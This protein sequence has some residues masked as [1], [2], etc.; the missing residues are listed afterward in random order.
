MT[1]NDT[2]FALSSGAGRAAIAVLRISGERSSFVI[3]E[4]TGQLPPARQLTVCSIRNPQTAELLDKGAVIWVPGP[5]SVTGEDI[6]ELHLHGSQAI[7]IE[8]MSL[9][10]AYPEVRPAEAGEFTR[11]AFANGKMDLIEVEG[12]SDLLEARTAGQRRQAMRQ[13]S[14]STSFTFEDWRQ[15]L[16]GIRASIEAAVDF[17]DEPGV[18]EL[19][20]RGLDADIKALSNDMDRAL[21]GSAMSEF[22]RE[23]VRVVLAGHPNTGK[24]SI[25]N[26]LVHRDVAIVSDRP[27]T[28]RDVIEVTLDMAGVPVI[29]T[30]TAG[31]RAEAT[32]SIELEGIRRT[33]DRIDKADLLIWVSAPDVPGSAA[34]APGMR[35]D[36]RVV[37]K[38]DLEDSSLGHSRND[39]EEPTV[40]TSTRTGAGMSDLLSN[41]KGLVDIRFGHM[42]DA[43]IVSSRQKT[44]VKRSIRLLNDAISLQSGS[45][46][47]K[48]ECIR[49]AADEVGRLTGR[50][51]VE[52]WLGAI[53]SRFCIGK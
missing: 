41:I 31:L 29:F 33:H 36:L 49:S 50:V 40:R 52:E 5:A 23:G 24:S 34:S 26:A 32:D 12:L 46:E 38:S 14:G 8:V 13:F 28:T 2:I 30:D 47:L 7:L 48:A 45:L 17:V 6:A 35:V 27:G 11:R 1:G 19:A 22:L 16:L 15:R 10:Q 9:L 53:F 51:D 20:E 43:T 3:R 21:S 37:N 44:I 4:L 18:A 39:T 25:L 42:E